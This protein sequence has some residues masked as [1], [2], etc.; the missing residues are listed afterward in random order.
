M[1]PFETYQ[2][3]DI[4]WRPC[5]AVKD[6]K[7]LQSV[8]RTDLGLRM[9]VMHALTRILLYDWRLVHFNCYQM[10][11]ILLHDMDFHIDFSPRWQHSSM[12]SCLRSL[13]STLLYFVKRERLP[14]FTLNHLNLWKGLTPRQ[15]TLAGGAIE[16]LLTNENAL[17]SLL[18]RA[19][20]KLTS[21]VDK[22]FT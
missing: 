1:F 22:K 13:L 2:E 8:T 15:L 14:H 12:E 5:F 19:S 6:N 11:T 20:S 3:G 21:G 17:I 7:L 18:R 16:R 9:S 10:Q 4:R